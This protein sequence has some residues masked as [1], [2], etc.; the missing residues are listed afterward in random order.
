MYTHQGL[1]TRKSPGSNPG[2]HYP[3]MFMVLLS[4]TTQTTGHYLNLR[5][6]RLLPGL[7]KSLHI[8]CPSTRLHIVSL[9]CSLRGRKRIFYT[10]TMYFQHLT[11]D[12]RVRSQANHCQTCGGR[13]G[14]VT[15]VCPNFPRQYHSTNA[16]HPSL[17]TCYS[18]QNGKRAKPGNLPQAM[19]FRTSGCTGQK[20]TV[21]LFQ[22]SAG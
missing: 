20:S 6:N 9:L 15:D 19:L 14:T 10:I 8:L 21:T 22:A 3:H 12:A 2:V 18:Y 7:H 16:P 5:H 13:S 11:K 1:Y 17:A 4:L